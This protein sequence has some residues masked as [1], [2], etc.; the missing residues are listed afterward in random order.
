MISAP[1]FATYLQAVE[2]DLPRALALYQW[3]MEVSAAL[4]MPL[5][6]CEVGTRNAVVEAIEIVHGANWPWSKGFVASLP[7]PR[8]REHYNPQ[9]NLKDVAQREPTAGKV[10]AQLNFAFWQQLFTKGQDERLWR[11]HLHLVLPGIPQETSVPIAR[12]AAFEALQ[13]IR[14]LRNRI[15]HHEPIFARDLLVDYQLILDV[16]GW[17]SPAAA[18]WVAKMLNFAHRLQQRP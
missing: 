14:R 17:R 12:A 15:A 8:R 6:I 1:R 7:Q 13:A 2:N 5:H 9:S 10:V 3:N 4:T 18:T 16:I 11:R